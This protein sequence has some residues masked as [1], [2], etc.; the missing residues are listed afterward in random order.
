MTCGC[1]LPTCRKCTCPYD[2][3]VYLTAAHVYQDLQLNDDADVRALGLEI[4]EGPGGFLELYRNP[5]A[6]CNNC[7]K[8]NKCSSKVNAQVFAA[9]MSASV[10]GIMAMVT[11]DTGNTG[12]QTF[13]IVNEVFQQYLNYGICCDNCYSE[14]GVPMCD[15]LCPVNITGLAL[16]EVGGSG[17]SLAGKMA[18]WNYKAP[19]I[20]DAFLNAFYLFDLEILRHIGQ[21]NLNLI[22]FRAIA[23]YLFQQLCIPVEVP[24]LPT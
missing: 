2:T 21:N 4:I 11:P 22:A 19:T 16:T 18:L 8:T 10:R 24:I 6:N 9:A 17:A 1:S 13:L 14:K 15:N 12:Y 20:C 3:I 7:K 23:H 5:T